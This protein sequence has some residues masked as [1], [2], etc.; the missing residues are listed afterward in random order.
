MLRPLDVQL[1]NLVGR[2]FQLG[3]REMK[4]IFEI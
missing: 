2:G 3:R 1:G 4:I